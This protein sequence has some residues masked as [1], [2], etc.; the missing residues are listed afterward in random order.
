MNRTRACITAVVA[1]AGLAFCGVAFAQAPASPPATTP[2]SA[3]SAPTSSKP[4]AA[5][6]VETWTR[7][8]WNS[9]QKEWAKDKAKWADCRKQSS[10]QNL[11][12]PKSWSFLSKCMT[13]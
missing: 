9:A 13:N 12:G 5:A 4:S 8:Q 1:L 3:A 10:K 6:Q 7:K 11:E 2:A